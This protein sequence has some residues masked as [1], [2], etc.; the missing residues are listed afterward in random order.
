MPRVKGCSRTRLRGTAL[1]EAAIV[2][3]L[4]MALIFGALQFSLLFW[5]M[6]Q[7]NNAAVIAARTLALADANTTWADQ[8]ISNLMAKA[9]ISVWDVDYLAGSG[10]QA[11]EYNNDSPP[12]AGTTVTVQ[13]TVGVAA[14]N[15][16]VMGW[17]AL[18][19][20]TA[21]KASASM[22]KEGP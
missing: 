5:R 14:N 4:L 13:L 6:Q 21:L 20:P 7:I 2:L 16:D 11:G 19:L 9:K 17:Q 18:L 15:L 8:C 12:A 1:V 3:P 10:E 22:A